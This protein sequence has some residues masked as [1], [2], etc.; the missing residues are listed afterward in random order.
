MFKMRILNLEEK[1]KQP[2]APL[3]DKHEQQFIQNNKTHIFL[4][5]VVLK[6]S[7]DAINLL[8]KKTEIKIQQS[9]KCSDAVT[10]AVWTER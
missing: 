9:N 3:D 4:P 6:D 7:V 10:S 2:A 5:L 1:A 8:K